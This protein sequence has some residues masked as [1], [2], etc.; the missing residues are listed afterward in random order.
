MLFTNRVMTF[1]M[2]GMMMIMNV[3]TVAN[4]VVRQHIRSIRE[5]MQVG[6]M[7]AFITYAM[8]IV[9][10][11]LMLDGNVDY[12][13]ACRQWLRSVL[14]RSSARTVFHRGTR[15]SRRKLKNTAA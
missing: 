7:T 1:M 5:L 10:A 13:S 3:L 12:A 14:M 9:M 8:M 4:C 6:S 15:C 2:P 11:F